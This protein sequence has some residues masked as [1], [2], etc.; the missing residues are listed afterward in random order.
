MESPRFNPRPASSTIRFPSRSSSSTRTRRARCSPRSGRCARLAARARLKRDAL[1]P[2]EHRRHA[3]IRAPNRD[4]GG[5]RARADQRLPGHRSDD[6]APPRADPE[7]TRTASPCATSGRATGPS[8]TGARSRPRRASARRRRSRS[9][10]SR[11]GSRRWTGARGRKRQP[12][13]ITGSTIVR[14]RAVLDARAGPRRRRQEPAEARHAARGLEGA[15]Q[16][17]GHRRAARTRSSATRTRFSR[18]T[19]SRSS[20]STSTASWC[21]KYRA[22]PQAAANTAARGAAV[23]RAHGAQRQGGHPHRQR[24]RGHALHRPVDRHA[25]DPV[26]DLRSAHGQ[27]GTRARRAL[28]RSVGSRRTDSPT[29]TSISASRSPASPP[30]R[31]RTASS[32]QRIQ[33]EMLARSN[34]ERFFTPQLAQAHRR[35]RRRRFASAA[36]SGPSPCC[37]ATSAASR[38]SPSRCA[39]R[40]SPACSPSISPRWWIACSGTKARWTSSWATRSWRSGARRSAATDDADNADGGGDRHDAGSSSGLNAELA[41]DRTSRAAGRHRLELRRSVRRQ[42]RLGAATRV[43]RH[44]RHGEHRE[45]SVLRRRRRRDPDHRRI[46]ARAQGPC[47]N[48]TEC[49]PMELKNKSAAG[50]RVSR[51]RRLMESAVARGSGGLRPHSR[52][53][54]VDVGE[55]RTCSPRRFARRCESAC[56]AVRLRAASSASASALAGRGIAYAAPLPDGIERRRAP[57]PARRAASAR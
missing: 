8:S 45:P 24:R 27:R 30:S 14:Q 42:H 38:R 9:A 52:S 16:G 47:R 10:R 55:H 28:R 40:K 23:D 56:D 34:F 13:A 26:G 37:S 22:R 29:T 51:R 41:H 4:L 54:R 17:R 21:P 5:R 18:S 32:S 19:A 7:A 6:L 46:P 25:A 1:P 36:T 12:T 31:S 15:R 44:R 43:H 50:D 48:L 35:F 3:D 20:S 33:R 2:R 53:A 11:S 57:Q 49:P 39:P